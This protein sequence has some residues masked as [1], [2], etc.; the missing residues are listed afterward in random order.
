MLARSLQEYWSFGFARRRIYFFSYFINYKT[1]AN[2]STL[3]F[4]RACEDW[5]VRQS[6]LE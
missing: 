5:R 2:P 3:L 6:A 1:N 4:G